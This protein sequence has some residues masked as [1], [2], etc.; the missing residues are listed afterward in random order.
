MSLPLNVRA[1]RKKND[2]QA[3]TLGHFMK[4]LY[5]SRIKNKVNV[6]EGES[7]IRLKEELNPIIESAFKRYMIQSY[8]RGGQLTLDK[9]KIKN[10]PFF[11]IDYDGLHAIDN[12]FRDFIE[13]FWQYV[14]RI[15][16]RNQQVN[17][18]S[19]AIR[20]IK[21]DEEGNVTEKKNELESS[22]Y[23]LSRSLLMVVAAYNLG[24]ALAPKYADN[25]G[26]DIKIGSYRYE[27]VSKRDNLVCELCRPLDDGTLYEV[28]DPMLPDPPI[29][30]HCR[31]ILEMRRFETPP[32]T[33]LAGVSPF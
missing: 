22:S 15:E 29:H 26:G 21:I 9:M 4:I 14:E 11:N 18:V 6:L 19:A 16:R 27:F 12:R 30:A 32:A 17:P 1:I 2:A 20:D 28:G 13:R 8:V 7:F 24:V 10:V 23:M 5:N 3:K 33:N 25:I 31:C